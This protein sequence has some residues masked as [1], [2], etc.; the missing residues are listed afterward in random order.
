MLMMGQGQV[1]DVLSDGLGAGEV[2]LI[3]VAVTIV[4]GMSVWFDDWCHHR[5]RHDGDY[6]QP[7]DGTCG[8]H[9]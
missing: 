1:P 4:V 8:R 7:C 6:T 2:V 9:R 5:Q 3:V